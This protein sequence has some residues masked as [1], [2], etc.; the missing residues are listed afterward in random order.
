MLAGKGSK[1]GK[2]DPLLARSTIFLTAP[3]SFSLSKIRP[4]FQK[5]VMSETSLGGY[6][7]TIVARC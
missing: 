7:R 2:Q 6:D 4:P 1:A 3:N 5:E